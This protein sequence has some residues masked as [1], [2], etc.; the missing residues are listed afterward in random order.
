MSYATGIEELGM[1]HPLLSGAVGGEV[2]ATGMGDNYH[3][4]GEESIGDCM[5]AEMTGRSGMAAGF[6]TSLFL[7]LAD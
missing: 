4:T 3:Y 5:I 1:D 6:W 7:C 2:G